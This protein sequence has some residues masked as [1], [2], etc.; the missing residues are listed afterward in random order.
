MEC[1]RSIQELKKK[2]PVGGS[3]N[4]PNATALTFFK[5]T[6]ISVQTLC[7]QVSVEDSAS[8]G[9]CVLLIIISRGFLTFAVQNVTW[10]I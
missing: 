2:K 7:F 1:V 10:D 5:T 8:G 4:R 3:L 6:E 9:K